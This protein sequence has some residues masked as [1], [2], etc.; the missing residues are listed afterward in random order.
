LIE[1]RKADSAAMEQNGDHVGFFFEMGE[2][3]LSRAHLPKSKR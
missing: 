1:S 3:I 2:R